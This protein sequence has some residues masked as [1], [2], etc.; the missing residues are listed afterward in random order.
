MRTQAEGVRTLIGAILAAVGS[1]NVN[2]GGDCVTAVFT[3]R[4]VQQAQGFR[5]RG[6]AIRY[7]N[8]DAGR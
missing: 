1:F 7:L 2:K 5:H 4:L 8:E 3:V 6:G